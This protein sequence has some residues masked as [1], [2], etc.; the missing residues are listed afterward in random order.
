M[1]LGYNQFESILEMPVLADASLQRGW[2][3]FFLANLFRSY[4]TMYQNLSY[5]TF[6]LEWL[7]FSIAR[8]TRCI[9]N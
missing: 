5:S 7:L 3:R 8:D 6:I 1:H 2:S 4:V 9:K